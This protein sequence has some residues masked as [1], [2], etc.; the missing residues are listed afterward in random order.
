MA[1]QEERQAVWR[2][3]CRRMPRY[4]EIIGE[5]PEWAQQV[6]LDTICEETWRRLEN[7]VMYGMPANER[8][9]A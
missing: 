7:A 1:T 3:I 9:N 6:V 4:A 8:S 5:L 2:E